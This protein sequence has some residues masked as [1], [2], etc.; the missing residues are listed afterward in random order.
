VTEGK[1]TR[2]ARL[3]ALWFAVWDQAVSRW[4]DV[5]DWASRNLVELIAVFGGYHLVDGAEAIFAPAGDLLRG[6]LLIVAAVCLAK[7]R[8]GSR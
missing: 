7:S 6:A 1:P 4:Y 3:L 2:K 8:G 5:R